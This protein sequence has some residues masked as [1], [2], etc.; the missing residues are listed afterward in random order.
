MTLAM[1]SNGPIDKANTG[2]PVVVRLQRVL[3]PPSDSEDDSAS[4]MSDGMVLYDD[5]D[6]CTSPVREQSPCISVEKHVDTVDRSVS[7]VVDSVKSCNEP[8]KPEYTEPTHEPKLLAPSSPVVKQVAPIHERFIVEVACSMKT[9]KPDTNRKGRDSGYANTLDEIHAVL[10]DRPKSAPCRRPF[11]AFATTQ[12]PTHGRLRQYPGRDR[13]IVSRMDN[14]AFSRSASVISKPSNRQLVRPATSHANL[15]CPDKSSDGQAERA[16]RRAKEIHA[17]RSRQ[18]YQRKLALAHSP[19]LPPAPFVETRPQ[20]AKIRR[21]VPEYGIRRPQSQGRRPSFENRDEIKSALPVSSVCLRVAPCACGEV[22][23][24]K[25]KL[26]GG[27]FCD[28]PTRYGQVSS[29]ARAPQI[30]GLTPCRASENAIKEPAM[31]NIKKKKYS[32]R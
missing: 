7:P 32:R 24:C 18:L 5:I 23:R 16:S 22:C 30:L 10:F 3:I 9:E 19:S 15:T 17:E 4:D 1:N 20:T 27:W 6:E 13:M 12:S 31:L 26:A 28:F 14:D 25:Q 11:V 29:R 8:P 2:A 21:E